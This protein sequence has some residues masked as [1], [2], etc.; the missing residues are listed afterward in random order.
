MKEEFITPYFTSPPLPEDEEEED[1]SEAEVEDEPLEP[2]LDPPTGPIDP[3]DDLLFEV[4]QTTYAA[5]ISQLDAALAD[6][7]DGLPDDVGLL[8]T[9]DSRP[10]A[11]RARGRRSGASVAAPRDRPGAAAAAS[12]RPGRPTP[13]VG[14]D[15]V[16]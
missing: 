16:H 4:I 9:S 14:A 11:G 12:A 6:L 3:E 5:A 10:G 15:A 1:E 2:L 8:L 7:L 13:G